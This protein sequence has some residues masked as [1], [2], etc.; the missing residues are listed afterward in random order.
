VT[1][2]RD[3][4]PR[5]AALRGENLVDLREADPRL[6][7]S[8]IGLLELGPEGL[9][10]AAAAAELGKQVPRAGVTLLAP[11]PRP[12]KV[13]C[14]GLNYRDHA[15]ESGVEPP[16]EPIVFNK[17]PSAIIG[18]DAA[19][20]LPRLSPRVDYEA[21]LVVVI[22][23]GGKHIPREDAL[24]HVA[25]YCCGHDVSARDWQ[26]TKPGKQWL[27][28]KTFDTFGP[29]GPMLVT[30]DEVG[31]PGNLRIQFRRNGQ[32]LQDSS[33]SQLI[34][35]IPDLIRYLSGVVRLSPGDVIFTGTPPGVGDARK[36]PIYL[37][38]GDVAE[39]EIDGLGILRNPCVAEPNA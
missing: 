32:T 13:F 10:W 39:V 29:L 37:Q 30:P 18:P 2:Q 1:Y 34:F 24:S 7:S 8:M 6:P 9:A 25:G 26:L 17:F 12:G 38:P 21:E 33:T 14:I 23:R 15:K 22:G 31:D 35:P 36:P 16:A 11:V 19:I 4:E 28:G 3:G 5:A 20:E 27:L